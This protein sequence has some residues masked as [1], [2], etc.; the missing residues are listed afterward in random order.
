MKREERF[1]SSPGLNGEKKKN[2]SDSESWVPKQPQ[3]DPSSQPVMSEDL[4]TSVMKELETLKERLKTLKGQLARL[5]TEQRKNS[6]DSP[7]PLDIEDEI[8]DINK[9]IACLKHISHYQKKGSID[10]LWEA[11]IVFLEN[12]RVFESEFYKKFISPFLN[13][14]KLSKIQDLIE[15]IIKKIQNLERSISNLNNEINRYITEKWSL[16]DDYFSSSIIAESNIIKCK[17]LKLL[18]QHI[19]I[20]L[21]SNAKAS[22]DAEP[23]SDVKIKLPSDT[24]TEIEKYFNS[25]CQLVF[26]FNENKCIGL[27]QKLY[28]FRC[29][30]II[31]ND[32]T[33]SLFRQFKEEFPNEFNHLKPSKLPWKNRECWL[34]KESLIF[35]R[36]Y[37]SNKKWHQEISSSNSSCSPQYLPFLNNLNGILPDYAV[38]LRALFIGSGVVKSLTEGNSLEEKNLN[39]PPYLRAWLELIIGQTNKASA[40]VK[41][42]FRYN[43][44]YAK[45]LLSLIFNEI[46][47]TVS[48]DQG[49]KNKII[50]FFKIFSDKISFKILDIAD[51]EE[52][53]SF[54][55]II[56]KKSMNHVAKILADFLKNSKNMEK[57]GSII[58]ELMKELSEEE[59]QNFS[60]KFCNEF[61]GKEFQGKY[62]ESFFE[63]Y[64]KNDFC[65]GIAKQFFSL[66]KSSEKWCCLF[67][68]IRNNNYLNNLETVPDCL[69]NFSQ[70]PSMPKTKDFA[71]LLNFLFRME[72]NLNELLT[73]KNFELFVE[74]IVSLLKS[75]DKNNQVSVEILL[76]NIAIH[77]YKYWVDLNNK[78]KSKLSEKL[79]KKY[80]FL[81]EIIPKND[82]NT[83]RD[84][85]RI[86]TWLNDE[87]K[88]K[89]KDFTWIESYIG[90]VWDYLNE[91][92][93]LYVKDSE[94]LKLIMIAPI[95]ILR[96][97]KREFFLELP[98]YLQLLL[99]RNM[100]KD[101]V[102]KEACLKLINFIHER[103]PD[104]KKQNPIEKLQA[105][106][107]LEIKKSQEDK[108]K[109]NSTPTSPDP[110]NSSSSPKNDPSAISFNPSNLSQTQNSSPTPPQVSYTSVDPYY[111]GSGYIPS[112][113]EIKLKHNIINTVADGN[114][115][116][117]AVFGTET[118]GTVRCESIEAVR[119][120]VAE[121]IINEY[122]KKGSPA[123]QYICEYIAVLIREADQIPQYNSFK[124]GETK[125][126]YDQYH[127]YCQDH[128]DEEAWK[129]FYDKLSQDK[130][131]D[132]CENINKYHQV[133]NEKLM[134]SSS[135]SQQMKLKFHDALNLDEKS[136]WNLK[137]AI[138]SDEKLRNAF[139]KFN[140]KSKQTFSWKRHIKLKHVKAFADFISR[141]GEY[142]IPIG[143][144]IIAHLY[145]ITIHFYS[146]PN[147]DTPEIYNPRQSQQVSV[148]HNGV[149]HYSR[150]SPKQNS[151]AG[152]SA[153]FF[154]Q[155]GAGDANKKVNPILLGNVSQNHQGGL[156]IF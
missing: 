102:K 3:D 139:E 123:Y 50:D 58:K 45:E 55:F 76:K 142:I 75:S 9:K 103:F 80:N 19:K 6:I 116:F 10:S 84:I 56:S 137:D 66:M 40:L 100:L 156:G 136:K 128:S 97:P 63:N 132:I 129:E 70:K 119:K 133:S 148:E 151:T 113:P 73:I 153:G 78:I 7:D 135:P 81:W 127:K 130:Y 67:E 95:S 24:K 126:L 125:D 64:M 146:G 31:D 108:S 145:H 48:I 15:C 69:R 34:E 71:N 88:I 122:K 42:L 140:E 11:Y 13:F 149:N 30:S 38:Q 14:N 1:P 110:S 23:S 44:G 60:K 22:S 131:K 62:W 2:K 106:I 101:P 94:K 54:L 27:K 4:S 111:Y 104:T 143:L 21:L 115:A 74:Y 89:S 77:N 68:E 51:S 8:S 52:T 107:Q 96:A 105:E 83:V 28:T 57:V 36:C 39:R 46:Q 87:K 118:N 32:E 47:K 43:P 49:I 37:T 99:K 154:S 134:Q 5:E 90:I 147:V 85:K 144:G 141:P 112:R 29:S 35:D 98:S 155:Q 152:N 82:D 124:K 53:G 150:V 18:L 121:L 79:R 17:F 114:C 25:T 91:L 138:N 117:H 92:V 20:Y 86:L 16:A 12:R 65:I 26:E 109:T 93:D 33:G 120:G 72:A 61:L 41:V 59:K